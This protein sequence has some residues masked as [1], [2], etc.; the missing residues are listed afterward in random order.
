MLDSNIPAK[1]STVWAANASASYIRVIPATQ[2]NGAGSASYSLGFPPENAT[3]VGAGGTPPFEQDFNGILNIVTAW[4]QWYQAGAP[5]PY[6]STFQTAIGGYP[7]GA[8]VASATTA[9]KFWLATT[10]GNT[11]NPDTGGAGWQAL[12]SLTL[13][14][15]WSG[16]NVIS[17]AGSLAFSGAGNGLTGSTTN[18]A[19]SAGIVGEYVTA[20]VTKGSHVGPLTSGTAAVV[21]S[22]SITAGD[23]DISGVIGFDAGGANPTQVLGVAGQINTTSAVVSETN[24]GFTWLPFNN[25]T[26]FQTGGGVDPVFAVPMNRFSVAAPTTI[27]LNAYGVFSAGNLYAWGSIS[28][29]RRR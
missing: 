10:D 23:W 29:R 24:Y 9:G 17:G 6:D 2:I 8:I 19:A 27:Y 13:G 18:D 4:L 14:Q 21:T 5:V 3:P 7:K 25:A 22:I 12:P 11:T 1:F 26:I 16:A 20:S 28:A 15:T